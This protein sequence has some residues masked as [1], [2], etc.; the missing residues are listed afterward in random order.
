MRNRVRRLI[1]EKYVVVQAIL[2]SDRFG[3][4]IDIIAVVT[5]DPPTT[6]KVAREFA[7]HL[8]TRSVRRVIGMTDLIVE[9]GFADEQSLWDYMEF[10]ANIPGI[11]DVKF[12]QCVRMYK[13]QYALP[14]G[15]DDRSIERSWEH[16]GSADV[17]PELG[18][19]GAV[20]S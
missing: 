18:N 14:H 11:R 19:A 10:A 20:R 8:R 9:A 15:W 12:N 1:R 3:N 4:I 7:S 17:Q 5:T 13:G 6:D 2:N 16:I